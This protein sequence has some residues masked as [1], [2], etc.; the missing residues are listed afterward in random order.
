MACSVK[1]CS[2]M[3]KMFAVNGVTAMSIVSWKMNGFS[4]GYL[5][6]TS[7]RMFGSS[8]SPQF[9]HATRCSGTGVPHVKQVWT[10]LLVIES[11][12]KLSKT[13]VVIVYLGEIP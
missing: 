5:V 2:G 7:L 8:I 11:S 10:L 13:T 12:I 1:G 9:Q 6:F 4:E 3:R